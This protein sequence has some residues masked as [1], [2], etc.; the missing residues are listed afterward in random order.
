VAGP[1]YFAWTGGTIQAPTVLVTNGSLHGALVQTLTIVGDSVAGSPQIQNIASVTGLEIGE[2]YY[3]S[4]PG[5]PGGAFFIYDTG[6]GNQP[7]SS[8]NLSTNATATAAAVTLT[9]TKSVVLGTAI[10]DLTQG[11]ST[12]EFGGLPVAPGVYGVAGTG[13]GRTEA[14]IETTTGSTAI[15]FRGEAAV[16]F[17]P[18]AYIEYDGG[19][20]GAMLT[21]VATAHHVTSWDL[22]TGMPTTATTW[23]VAAQSVLATTSGTFPILISGPPE[24]DFFTVDNIPADALA[25]LVPGL[26][27]NI[28]GAGIQ[29][30][31][32]FVA[33]AAGA[34]SITLDLPAATS[35]LAALLTITG[36]RVPN[37]PFDPVAHARV[38][39]EILGFQIAQE[40]GGFATLDIDLK[41]PQ[42]G[43]LATG[44]NLWCWL[45]WDQNWTPG[46][47]AT[48]SLLPLFNGRLV[49]VP[50]LQAGEVVQLKFL[51][52]PDDYV[53][54]K[55]S[56]NRDLA[57][58]PYYDPIWL[59]NNINPDT[60]LES[61][62][63]LWHI[64][65][66]TLE[67]TASDVLVGE[68]GTITIGEDQAFYDSFSLS[69]GSP[70]L[71]Q[72][73]I[74]GA[75][76]WQQQGEGF[77]DITNRIISEFNAVGSPFK[78]P[79]PTGGGTISCL[80]GDG[81]KTDWPK[82]GASIGGG[83]SL[84]TL[85]DGRGL[86]YNYII[87]AWKGAGGWM[88]PQFYN[89]A[90]AGTVPTVVTGFPAASGLSAFFA[91]VAQLSI[92]FPVNT[93]KI[94]M[95]L[96]YKADRKRT[97][98]VAAVMT[99]D[100][101]QMLSDTSDSDR[102]SISYSSQYV[103]QAVDAD[104]G[105]PIADLRQRTYFQTDRGARSFEYLLLVARAK[106]RFR[107]RAVDIAIGLDFATALGIGLRNS[108]TYTDRRIPGGQATGKVKSY[109]ITVGDG[110]MFGEL[111]IGC[112]IGNGNS[113][114]AA[115][116]VNSYVDDAYV[117]PPYQVMTGAQVA[118]VTSELTY[119]PLDSFVI[120][121]DGLDLTNLTV[122]TAMNE[123]LVTNGLL[124]QLQRLSVFQGTVIPV[125]G[126]PISTMQT[127]TTT[128]T[129]DMRPVA[130]GEFHTDFFPAVSALALP[131]MI[132][133]GFSARR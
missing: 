17:V 73:S 25:S 121:D 35:Q 85:N 49:G 119:Q 91:P 66:T 8:I 117:D 93:Y 115:S 124:Y 45:S 78:A 13:I 48:P 37:A 52:R 60:V 27:Y 12:L 79:H 38:D 113:S 102:E 114:A 118:L 40:E 126:D 34:T 28:S 47:S 11:S 92:S 41:N 128:C 76:E 4:G 39:E 15:K 72:V 88:Q 24:T 111:V 29:N 106:M 58:L 103:A 62:S 26:R 59:A 22:V 70:P 36:P 23:S 63:A 65:R 67:V 51:A 87:D 89:V 16:M 56:V 98:T 130:G 6:P 2:L 50:A 69:Y 132:D 112:A 3:I 18:A 68:D 44:R 1:F 101:Q 99:A 81:L 127:L 125:F 108:V 71:T 43:L 82:P 64:D 55:D 95:T 86:P 19:A 21:L 110:G 5:I 94:R 61:Y 57:V 104:G 129:L 109:R 75:V 123:F 7:D 133:L 120:D 105:V 80:C 74:S 107:A 33:P 20:S 30:G 97:E 42:I 10:A 14:P 84:T 96:Q 131:K 90:L 100:V 31:S 32:T 9:L 46:G 77:I 122:D 83:W 53:E 116:G 54:Q